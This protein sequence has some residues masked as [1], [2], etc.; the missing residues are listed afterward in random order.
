MS[1][2]YRTTLNFNPDKPE[3]LKA[4][5]HLE[6]LRRLRPD[7]SINDIMARLLLEDAEHASGMADAVGAVRELTAS[8]NRLT[9]AIR[10]TPMATVAPTTPVAAETK[11]ENAGKV[12]DLFGY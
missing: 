5:R 4:H 11:A 9:E 1:K 3:Q 7:L 6:E 8:M 12:F 10:Q 2:I